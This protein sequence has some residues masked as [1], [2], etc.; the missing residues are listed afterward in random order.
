M[1]IIR[2][3]GY[4]RAGLIG[5]PS[6]GYHGKTIS[7][8]LRNFYADVILYEW[9]DLELILS[10]EDHSRFGSIQE[11]ARDV[12]LHGYYGG[13]RL[14][15]ATVKKFVDYC[16]RQGF[17]LHDR[18]FT[19]R[20]ESNIPRQVGL[21]GSSAIIVATLHALMEFYGVDIPLYLQPSLV[22]SVETD[23][24]GIVGGLQDRVIQV[25]GGLVYMDFA[26]EVMQQEC[27]YQYGRY[28]LLEPSLLPP[29]YVAYSDEEGEPTEV[30]HRPL[31]V[32][33]DQGDA[34]VVAAM[35]KFARLAEDARTAMLDKDAARLSRL[36]DENFDTRRRICQLQPAHVRMV[37]TARSAGA[38]AK[39]AGSGGAIIGVYQ[40]EAMYA[41]LKAKLEGI[42]CHVFKPVVE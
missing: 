39:Y 20:Y 28:E 25:Y 7:L 2:H 13:I 10:Q 29:V 42:G 15:K 33:Y 40:D 31:R 24:L 32:R 36:M 1:Q 16:A 19:V 6:D 4:A 9:E 38:S 12:R 14:V 5:N 41:E 26:R 34:D 18:N 21:A 22:L 17:P 35:T 3:R 11:L 37:E 8:I 23:E 27:G 30:L